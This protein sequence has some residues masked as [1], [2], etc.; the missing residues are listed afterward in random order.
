VFVTGLV[1]AAGSSRRLGRPKQLLPYR[2]DTLLGVSVGQAHRA[3]FDQLLVTVGGSAADVRAGVDLT[4]VTVVDAPGF[5]SGCSASIRSALA[6]VDARSD[7]LVL[8]LG[9]QPGIDPVV[10]RE[11]VAA[12]GPD[13]IGVC[14][15]TDGL[16]HPM[17]FPRAAFADL[18]A[19]HGDKAVWKLVH[20]GAY[21]LTEHPVPG[22][23]P[24]DVDTWDDYATLLAAAGTGTIGRSDS[25]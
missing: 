7:G 17:W 3:G 12:A 22:P 18:A 4:G 20:A 23:V 16:G 9:D 19:M 6:A 13:A 5:E 2:D 8:L 11:L 24:I 21:P 10:I 1:L 14:S 25:I 15:Y